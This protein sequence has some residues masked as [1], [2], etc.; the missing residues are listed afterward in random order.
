MT[1]MDRFLLELESFCNVNPFCEFYRGA[2]F[3]SAKELRLKT[4]FMTLQGQQFCHKIS[5]LAC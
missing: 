1:L 4:I 3:Q 5:A 2:I